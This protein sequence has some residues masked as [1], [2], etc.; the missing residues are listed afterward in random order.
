MRIRHSFPIYILPTCV[1]LIT[2]TS[3]LLNTTYMRIRHSF[4]IYIRIA[5]RYILTYYVLL[6]TYYGYHTL[7][8]L[9]PSV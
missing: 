6:L 2:I 8:N 7:V 5:C 9:P 3:V 1:L 4:P